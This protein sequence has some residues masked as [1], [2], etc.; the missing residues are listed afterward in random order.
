MIDVL[1]NMTV[2]VPITSQEAARLADILAV[3]K[4]YAET[5]TGDDQTTDFVIVHD[6]GTTDVIVQI[7]DAITGETIL[8]DAPP[9]DENS[10]TVQFITPP[11]TGQSYRVIVIASGS[12]GSGGSGT[13]NHAELTNLDYASSGHTGFVS[14]TAKPVVQGIIGTFTQGTHFTDLQTFLNDNINNHWLPIGDITININTPVMA[15]IRLYNIFHTPSTTSASTITINTSV[16]LANVLV[17]Q[18]VSSVVTI[19]STAANNVVGYFRMLNCPYVTFSGTGD[20]GFTATASVVWGSA[21]TIG[22]NTTDN[23]KLSLSALQIQAGSMLFCRPGT[24]SLNSLLNYADIVIYSTSVLT[25]T[26]LTNNGA[27][28]DNRTNN[29]SD[30]FLR[31][32]GIQDMKI[33]KV[34]RYVLA[35][36]SLGGRGWGNV[37]VTK[38]GTGKF[39]FDLSGEGLSITN[40]V[41]AIA[42]STTQS[43]NTSVPVFFN[44][45]TTT[46]PVIHV[47]IKNSMTGA[48]TDAAFFI[49]IWSNIPQVSI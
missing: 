26:T 23:V 13:D 40:S 39:D 49:V 10:V 31:K 43:I 5:I 30:T 18:N 2:P 45:V 25:I 6:L 14:Q 37:I 7:R 17:M 27:I 22:G 21:L 41:L 16:Q 36:G 24:I 15:N 9:I 20:F 38:I 28:F 29:P 48:L 47:E 3:V 12:D 33:S 35:D 1:S 11:Q 4:N 32:N 8:V 44:I 46:T 42:T 19:N 34:A